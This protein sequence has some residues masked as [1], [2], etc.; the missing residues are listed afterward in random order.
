[1]DAPETPRRPPAQ[2]LLD[3]PLRVVNV[4]VQEFA[5]DLEASQRSTG[6]SV[7]HVD[8]V[9][10]ANGDARMAGLLSKLGC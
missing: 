6:A 10:P 7:L 8:W 1:M 2:A 4:G 3:N 5:R 9:P